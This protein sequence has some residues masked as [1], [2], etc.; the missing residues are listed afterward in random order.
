MIIL[1]NQYIEIILHF[2]LQTTEMEKVMCFLWWCDI[3]FYSYCLAV[4]LA[5]S[6]TYQQNLH[7]I[8]VY[9][10]TYNSYYKHGIC[11]YHIIIIQ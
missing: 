5:C 7:T 10:P 1:F 8:I 4:S 6:G 2:M 11:I 3:A 9:V